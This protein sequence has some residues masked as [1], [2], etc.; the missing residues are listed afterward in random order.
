MPLWTPLLPHKQSRSEHITASSNKQQATSIKNFMVED[1]GATRNGNKAKTTIGRTVAQVVIS[2][3]RTSSIEDTYHHLHVFDEAWSKQHHQHQQPIHYGIAA[4]IIHIWIGILCQPF[5]CNIC[6]CS[7]N[8]SKEQQQ[9]LRPPSKI[10]C[11]PRSTGY[12]KT[13]SKTKSRDSCENI[14]RVQSTCLSVLFLGGSSFA[15]LFMQEKRLSCAFQSHLPVAGS[16]SSVVKMGGSG[17]LVVITGLA[18][19][20]GVVTLR[21]SR[22]HR[23]T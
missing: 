16:G 9:L 7:V 4:M 5:D 17:G 1:L 22:R 12:F 13:R 11:C 10:L 8:E 6:S 15:K 19:S 23:G 2:S 20:A 14:C 18:I 3:S 21:R